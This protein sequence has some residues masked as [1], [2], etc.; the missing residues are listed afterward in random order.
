M[1]KGYQLYVKFYVKT[2]SNFP[3]QSDCLSQMHFTRKFWNTDGLGLFP[4]PS[5]FL[6]RLSA[7]HPHH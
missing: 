1:E 4:A 6:H 7:S 5:V 3:F 2:A